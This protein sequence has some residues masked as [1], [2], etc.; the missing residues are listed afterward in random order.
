M[1]IRKSAKLYME[2]KLPQYQNTLRGPAP[3]LY[4]HDN[5][6]HY[7]TLK[8]PF[9]LPKF[10]YDKKYVTKGKTNQWPNGPCTDC[11]K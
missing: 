2:R 8:A 11:N 10:S 3:Q 7:I 9:P 4:L 5:P 1:Q 6:V